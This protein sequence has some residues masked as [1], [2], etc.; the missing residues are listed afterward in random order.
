MDIPKNLTKVAEQRLLKRLEDG[1]ICRYCN[2]PIKEQDLEFTSP[3]YWPAGD[4]CPCHKDCKVEGKKRE[5]YDCQCVDADCNDCLFFKRESNGRWFC[6]GTC[7]NP[8]STE[9]EQEVVAYPNNASL[10]SCFKH[11]KSNFYGDS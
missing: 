4:E 8:E 10:R 1:P 9:F 6:K 11:R 3:Y 2:K 5:A 7:T